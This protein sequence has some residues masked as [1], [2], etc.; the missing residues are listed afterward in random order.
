MVVDV[1]GDYTHDAAGEYPKGK[2]ASGWVVSVMAIFQQ[3]T[4]NLLT[5]N[6]GQSKAELV[7][8]RFPV[9]WHPSPRSRRGLTFRM[10]VR[11]KQRHT[12]DHPLL[13]VI[14]EPVLA[15]FEAGNDRMPRRCRMLGCML[16]WGTVAA[17]DMPTLRTSAQ[18]KPPALG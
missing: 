12:F 18:V 17:P 2:A 9:G 11:R 16:V 1:N 8:E 6:S 10:C 15:G 7:Q 13:F 4:G 3:S 5:T 14:V